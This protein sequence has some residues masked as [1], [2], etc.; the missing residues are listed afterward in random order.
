MTKEVYQGNIATKLSNDGNS[1]KVKIIHGDLASRQ[2][3]WIELELDFK[4]W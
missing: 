4:P 2:G 1:A 3:T